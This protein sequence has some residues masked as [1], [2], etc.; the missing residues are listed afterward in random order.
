MGI[1]CS[2]I[3]GEIRMNKPIPIYKGPIA[4]LDMLGFKEY[5][6]NYPIQT[7]INEYAHILTSTSFTAEVMNEEIEFMVY[8]D[9]IAIRP[10]NTADG[11]FYNFIRALQLISHQYFYKIQ[12]PEYNT[13]PIRGAISYGEY[14]WYKGDISTQVLGR[15]SITANNL[16]FIVG[17]AIID[18]HELENKQEWI[19]IS[20]DKKTGDI[21]KKNFKD[22]FE[23]LEKEKYI[24]E[25]KIP[26]KKTL[27]TD[28]YVINP[29]GRSTFPLSFKALCN[30]CSN[31]IDNNSGENVII[32]YINTLKLMR[33]IYDDNDLCP[34]MKEI[35]RHDVDMTICDSLL[36]SHK[37]I[38]TTTRTIK[39]RKVALLCCSFVR[40]YAY[41]KA[42]WDNKT[43]KAHNSF[44][45][46]I[47][48]NF[49]DIAVLEWMK[50]FGDY[51]NDV[52]HW[53]NIVANINQFKNKMLIDCGF[54][55]PEF[56]QLRKQIKVYRDNFV[57]HLDSNDVMN[58]PFL[59][60]ALKIVY[61]YY[62]EIIKE[63]TGN[64]R[65][66]LPD[67]IESH[68]DNCF[69]EAEIY[70]GSEKKFP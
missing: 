4:I 39:L 33:K 3:L 32:K 50:L 21:F 25:E 59:M 9:T 36:I 15:K 60:N 10:L 68:Y 18:A 24:I 30:S 35:P 29:T 45:I 58:I 53:K 23:R 34:K 55:P 2:I 16:N 62:K 6:S 52:H 70:F 31:H 57:A 17:Q 19:G 67:D 26:V 11:G 12:I 20:F 47:Q 66:N 51:H 7:V 43:S 8:S 64:D 13:L 42:G 28:G 46:T 49:I 14:A 56:K 27:Y 63:L 69:K 41:Y 5:I 38:M 65:C 54:S 48:N 61:F 37:K 40:N 1:K 22:D 44:W